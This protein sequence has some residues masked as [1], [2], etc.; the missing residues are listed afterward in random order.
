MVWGSDKQ[1]LRSRDVRR[2]LDH[3]IH[4]A[5]RAV[6][7]VRPAGRLQ[8]RERRIEHL[9]LLRPPN[10]THFDAP[11]VPDY[12]T[13]LT[14]AIHTKVISIW[15]TGRSGTDANDP[16]VANLALNFGR[17]CTRKRETSG[18]VLVYSINYKRKKKKKEMIPRI[19][20]Y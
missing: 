17:V 1:L 3:L 14:H 20:S 18:A 9:R 6:Q 15:T 12:S 7:L 10:S 13:R 11:F 16:R 4:G 8:V 2:D 19:A 5:V